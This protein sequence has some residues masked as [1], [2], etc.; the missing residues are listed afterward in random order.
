MEIGSKNRSLMFPKRIVGFGA[1]SIY[2]RR[3]PEGS[4]FIGRLRRWH[5][6][7]HPNNVV[8][9]LG[10]SG[11]SSAELVERFALEVPRRR[12]Q[13]VIMHVGINDVRRVGSPAAETSRTLEQHLASVA[14]LIAL[15]RESAELFVVGQFPIDE[16]RTAPYA[17]GESFFLYKDAESYAGGVRDLCLRES[18]HFLDLFA[19]WSK[20]GVL[21][22][23]DEDGLHCNSAGHQ[24]IFY[25][26]RQRLES[27][28]GGL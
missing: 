27:I 6:P 28:Y 4:G 26:L 16:L 15:A 22:F 24:R 17:D 20:E 13:L 11:E 25:R 2:G 23:L 19:E 14:Q 8:Y 18:V 10:I 12:P 3:D 21:P 1:S 7:F 5:E 9:N